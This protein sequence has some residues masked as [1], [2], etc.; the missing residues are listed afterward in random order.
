MADLSSLLDRWFKVTTVS[1]P[2][3]LTVKGVESVSVRNPD[4]REEKKPIVY[5]L[6]DERGLVLNGTRYDVFAKAA[7]TRDVSKW[8]GIRF[9]LSSDPDFK[10]GGKKTGQLIVKVVN[11]RA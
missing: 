9:I 10:V 5:V 8:T 6:E 11:Q 7:G 1:S 2:I 3:T 4:G